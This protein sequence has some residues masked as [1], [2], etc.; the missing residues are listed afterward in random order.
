MDFLKER[1]FSKFEK[2]DVSKLGYKK[3]KFAAWSPFA[4][5]AAV[6]FYRDY[7]AVLD[8]QL[9]FEGRMEKDEDGCWTYSAS[10]EEIKGALF[11]KYRFSFDGEDIEV[12]DIWSKC[13]APESRASEL[14]DIS[15]D[16]DSF[17]Q[18]FSERYFNPFAE[19]GR[20]KTFS[21]AVIYEVHVR[22]WSRAFVKDSRGKFLDLAESPDFI[23]HLKE[24]GVTHVQFLPSFEYANAVSDKSYNWGYDPYNFNV[25]CSRYV[26]EGFTSGKKAA[27]D[28][29]KMIQTFHD[30][31]IAVN[32]DVV[33]N[34]TNDCG[35]NSIY[36][37]TVPGYFYRFS[38]KKYSNGSGCGNEIAS[39]HKIVKEFIIDSLCH[40]M[41][42]YHINGFRF[43]LMGV[44]EAETM[45]EIYRELKKIDP[46]V[47][48]YGEPWCG[49]QC[50]VVNGC[51]KENIDQCGGV[52]CFNDDFRDAIKGAEFAGFKKGQVQGIFND[53]AIARGLCG[54]L[55]KNGGFTEDC[56]RTINYVECHDNFTL[57][58]KLALSYLD[59]TS[60]SGDLYKEIG[61]QGLEKV[62]KQ[63]VLSAAYVIL[64]QGIPF[65]NGGQEFMRT[66]MGDDN[67]Y[68]SSDQI[69]QVDFDFK[70]KNADVFNCY[71]GLFALRRKYPEAFG[72]NEN[73]RAEKLSE[74]VTLYESGD[75]IVIYNA[76]ASDF[77]YE[78]CLEDAG[79][80]ASA[81]KL[82]DV[83]SGELMEKA[84]TAEPDGKLSLPVKSLSF[85]IL[86]K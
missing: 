73:A 79:V 86:K 61:S 15:R 56:N 70:K 64:A 3:G 38:D 48:V 2:V 1:D 47:L 37:M 54:S 74:G 50:A 28:M 49:G 39:N 69:N 33:Y 24:L 34:H 67:S 52:A 16:K 27:F 20:K 68:I 71:K 9:L 43:D 75:F 36:D 4:H 57:F 77:E 78:L 7:Q 12:C 13:A 11:Y 41:K 83:K 40:W 62:K 32:M 45:K 5:R 31:G 63:D 82:V 84:L 80:K 25:P 26:T 85:I 14:S 76:S 35:F 23:N 30:N 59:K 19:R 55:V 51:K 66:K 60:F 29:R 72:K 44:L 21:D 58:D 42:D 53:E 46:E 17:P 10:E 8:N 81:V 65:I 6:L 22:D 18:G